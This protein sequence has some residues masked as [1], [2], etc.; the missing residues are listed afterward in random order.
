MNINKNVW[1]FLEE[2][3]GDMTYGV[4]PATNIQLEVFKTNAKRYGVKDS[5]IKELLSLY[6]V[7][8]KLVF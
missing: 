3:P 4:Q 1:S 7:A 5:V 6:Q 2:L 8:N